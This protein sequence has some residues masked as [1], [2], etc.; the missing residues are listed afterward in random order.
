[1]EHGIAPEQIVATHRTATG[2]VDRTRPLCAYPK[3]ATFRGSGSPDEA[4][5]F[6]CRVPRD[7]FD[8][9]DRF[10]DDEDDD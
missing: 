1:V 2:T 3:E 8:R 4:S 6:V 5:S 9:H 10:D 7:L